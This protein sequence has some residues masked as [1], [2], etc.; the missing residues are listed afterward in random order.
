MSS[1]FI[2]LSLILVGMN[3]INYGILTKEADEILELLS[4]NKGSF[5]NDFERPPHPLPPHLS[6]ETPYESRYFWVLT[7]EAGKELACDVSKISSVDRESAV[8]YAKKALSKK[9]ESGFL[10]IYR[11]SVQ[12]EGDLTRITFLDCGR[13]IDSFRTFFFTGILMAAAGFLAVFLI[14]FLL[15][16]RI[17]RPIRESYEKQKRFITDAGHEI[18]TPLTVIHANVEILKMELGENESL[19]DIDQQTRRLHSLTEELIRLAR[20]EEKT[21][22]KIDFPLSDVATESVQ[23][24]QRT[25][26]QQKKHLTLHIQPNLTLTGNSGMIQNLIGIL[27]ENAIKYSPAEGEIVFR[28]EKQGRNLILSVFNTTESRIAPSQLDRIFDRFYRADDSR[29]SATGGHGIGLSIAK[30]IVEAHGGK[31]S[32]SSPQDRAF[33]ISATFP[34]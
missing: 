22:M 13:Q 19:A 11:F 12:K 3:G 10:G 26:A 15:S 14:I 34:C 1:L 8:G 17:L 7:D 2:L 5:P 18:K 28:L 6:P 4:C 30:R 31:I 33:L 20:M 24:F 25:A 32:A 27:M 21:M 16:E 9:S 29:N 23:P